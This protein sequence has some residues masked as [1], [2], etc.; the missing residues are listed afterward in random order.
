MLR[1]L[2]PKLKLV[3]PAVPPL[4]RNLCMT[5]ARPTIA[6]ASNSRVPALAFAS[7]DEEEREYRER[8]DDV[9]AWWKTDRYKDLKRTY[10]VEDVV[11]KRGESHALPSPPEP[12]SGLDRLHPGAA[13]IESNLD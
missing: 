12:P 10:A 9:A 6:A 4:A 8:C 5:L 1:H 13:A 3:R 2:Q 11:S 7:A